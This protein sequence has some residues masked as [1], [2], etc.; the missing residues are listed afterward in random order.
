MGFDCNV[1]DGAVCC[2]LRFKGRATLD[3]EPISGP[4]KILGI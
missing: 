4:E 3:A 2:E 1:F